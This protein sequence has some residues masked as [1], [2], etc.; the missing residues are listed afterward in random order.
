M[1]WIKVIPP[2][3][4]DEQLR[5]CYEEAYRL[6]PKEYMG[7]VDAVKRPDGTADSI[8]AAHSLIPEALRHL[9]AGFAVLLQPD[10]PLTRRQHE[11]IT[12]VVSSLNRCVY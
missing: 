6:Y 7:E 3:K 1:T 12:T 11:M 2:E 9:M 5:A 10:L 8:T 4:A